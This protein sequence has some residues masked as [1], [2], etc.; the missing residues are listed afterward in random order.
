MASAPANHVILPCFLDDYVSHVHLVYSILRLIPN[1]L[2]Y[3]WKPMSVVQI[4]VVS[5]LLTI[6]VDRWFLLTESTNHTEIYDLSGICGP[7][8]QVVFQNRFH[9]MIFFCVHYFSEVQLHILCC[10]AVQALPNPAEQSHAAMLPYPNS[11]LL[12]T[13]II[14][15]NIWPAKLHKPYDPCSPTLFIVYHNLCQYNSH[16]LYKI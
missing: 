6:G 12:S 11:L 8:R 14:A 15:R 2:T 13:P 9:C 10:I 16:S 1:I 4:N 3:I 5:D 7:L